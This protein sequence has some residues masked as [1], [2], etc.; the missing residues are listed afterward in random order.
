VYEN[1]CLTSVRDLFKIEYGVSLKE[2]S[3]NELREYIVHPDH[4]LRQKA[5]K[6]IVETDDVYPNLEN[7]IP[8]ERDCLSDVNHFLVFHIDILQTVKK[9]TGCSV[10][11]PDY[12]KGADGATVKKIDSYGSV[13]L[14]MPVRADKEWAHYNAWR[15]RNASN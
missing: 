13:L 9:I 3:G 8:L 12:W 5:G 14:V 4:K 15:G 6:K 10:Y 1:V 11:L 2:V 7:A